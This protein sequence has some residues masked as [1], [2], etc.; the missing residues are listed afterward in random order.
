LK[1][2]SYDQEKCMGCLWAWSQ[3][4]DE[5]VQCGVDPTC[6]VGT[7]EHLVAGNLWKVQNH[8]INTLNCEHIPDCGMLG[9]DAV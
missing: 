8:K 5:A 2:D 1:I 4:V 3:E 6:I 7:H 9:I